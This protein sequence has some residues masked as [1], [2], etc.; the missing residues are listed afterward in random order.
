MSNPI[1]SILVLLLSFGFGFFY[2]KPE[3]DTMQ[4]RRNDSVVL[5]ATLQSTNEI[6]S[7]I[8]QTGKTLTGINPTDLSRFSVFLPESIDPL[9][10]ANNLQ[11]IGF[12]H[13]IALTK[14]KVGASSKTPQIAPDQVAAS[15][16]QNVAAGVAAT[17]TAQKYAT[18]A[19][20]FD[21]NASDSAFNAF[22]GDIEKNLGLMNVTE[23]TF[24]PVA[25]TDSTGKVIKSS[26]PQYLYSMT[27]ETYSLN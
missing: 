20:T 8:Q 18:T 9:R 12:S 27:I 17:A 16:I 10:L 25:Q 14:I 7:L 1:I 6:Q 5:D 4:Q 3:Y 21:F 13:G 22:L 23:L 26:G 15:G 11:H 2:V 19:T 24:T